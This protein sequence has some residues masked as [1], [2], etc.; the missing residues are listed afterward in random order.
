MKEQPTGQ[1]VEES[2]EI[3][4]KESKWYDKK[5][6][7]I[8]LL[9]I[10]FPVGLYALWKS[11]RFSKMSK[12]IITAVVIAI[13]L[14]FGFMDEQEEKTIQDQQK[15]VEKKSNIRASLDDF[16]MAIPLLSQRKMEITKRTDRLE[17]SWENLSVTG[18]SNSATVYDDGKDGKIEQINIIVTTDN[19]DKIK[20]MESLALAY[21]FIEVASG[22]KDFM[23]E[24]INWQKSKKTDKWFGEVLVGRSV[25][26]A[27]GGNV[28]IFR[29]GSEE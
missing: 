8:I 6:L 21:K 1:P 13:L 17:Y 3:L 26:V 28:L 29:I 22:K 10:F 16:K 5:A 18:Q 7:V 9:V 20:T 14:I 12:G 25:T 23:S 4:K 19:N 27:Q 24:F 15:T 2:S 11:N